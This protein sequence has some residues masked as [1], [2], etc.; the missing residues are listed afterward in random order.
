ML[1]HQWNGLG[2]L[3][4]RNESDENDWPS[5]HHP[6]RRLL[7]RQKVLRSKDVDVHRDGVVWRWQ[8]VRLD[9]GAERA[10]GKYTRR[11]SAPD[12]GI[13]AWGPSVP[14]WAQ[15]RTPRYQAVKHSSH[16][17]WEFEVRRARIESWDPDI[18]L[19]EKH[20]GR[21]IRWANRHLPAWMCTVFC[22]RLCS[23]FWDKWWPRGSSDAK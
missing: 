18:L 14:P 2:N 9:W 10:R 13:A 1:S 16:I 8:L 11:K 6:S 21:I 22:L 23:S 5:K 20:S 3:W 7:L 17:G 12:G 4:E 15:N 19:S